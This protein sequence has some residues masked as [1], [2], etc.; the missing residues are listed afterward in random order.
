MNSQG[1]SAAKAGLSVRTARRVEQATALPSRRG[2]RTWRTREDPLAAVWEAEAV[3]LL[4]RD[5]QLNAVTLLAELRKSLTLKDLD[6]GPCGPR[7]P[8]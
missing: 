4:E 1:A 2:P 5:A 7:P 3:P 6:L 8:A